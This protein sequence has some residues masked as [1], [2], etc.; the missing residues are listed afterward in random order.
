MAADNWFNIASDLTNDSSF[1]SSVDIM[2]VHY[3]CG[4]NAPE[5][6]CSDNT[7]TPIAEKLNMPIWASESGTQNYDAGAIPLARALNRDYIDSRMTAYINWSLIA[8]WYSTLPYYGDGLMLA[9]Q[10]WSGY[11]H[12]G[13]SIWVDAQTTQFTGIGWQYI[14]SACGFLLGN[15]N[16]G[17]YVT[18]K[19]PGGSD[20]TIIIETVDASASQIAKFT[21]TGGFSVNT[22][23]VWSTN[24]N[25]SDQST[26]FVQQQD[27]TPENGIF[28][29]SLKQ[30]FV[31][32]LSTTS[33]QVKG[34]T[35][36]PSSSIL[37][38][39]YK[40]NFDEYPIGTIPKYFD[41][42]Q[43]A[44]EVDSCRGGRTGMCM[45]QEINISPDMWPGG[46]PT[47]PLA[48]VGDPGWSNYKVSTDALIEQ[49]G[50]I[51]LIGR[52]GAQ[53]ESSPGASQG[54]HLRLQ[55][56]GT[57]TLFKEDISGK[58]TQ[59]GTGTRLFGLNSWHNLSLG[60]NADTINAYIDS[61]LV[62]ALN[63]ETYSTGQAGILVSKWQNAEFDNFNI[64]GTG[65]SSAG[66]ITVDDAMEGTGINSFNYIGAGWQHCTACG[67]D[68]YNQTNSWD[69]VINDYVTVEFFGTQIK[70]YGVHD[71]G[72][73]IG[74]ISVDGSSET[75]IDFYA[76]V[77]DGDQL[78]WTSPVLSDS[79]HV[80][81]L[82]VTGSKNVN[83][84]NTWVV[85]DRV[86]ILSPG[87]TGVKKTN[88]VPAGYY[89]F[90][91][92]PNPFNPNTIISY[93]LPVSSGVILKVYDILGRDVKTL[94]NE[95]Q[96]AG[97]YNVSFNA[98]K[99]SS[100]IYFYM[101]NAIGSNGRSFNSVKKMLYLK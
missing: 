47:A 83:S 74:A 71:P 97:K 13:K 33:G 16:N 70:F 58:D 68:L 31:Y 18:L 3:P 86:D 81:K 59:L 60:F 90:Q 9:D 30:G 72:H 34:A 23:H 88:I 52:L 5:L 65:S 56:N 93:Q 73:G 41:S 2:G 98:S 91:N 20:Y 24:L 92:Q 46:S 40:E 19:S 85:P 84:T 66:W 67:T 75:N 25:S 101:L 63:D 11:Y 26:Y 99:L 4:W 14:D 10:P 69:N 27:I 78:M 51:E 79:E 55:S 22:L 54:Y 38:L 29:I 15:R 48:V 45:R 94:V 100:G 76:A 36:P 32:T 7:Y 43:G 42:I 87:V 95:Q 37:N 44:F 80:F 1:H 12:V 17:S 49:T 39:P 61:I 8:A 89:L 35:K 77:R 6:V 62:A 96:S 21:V 50:Y 82:R 53:S 28:T 57:W 64:T